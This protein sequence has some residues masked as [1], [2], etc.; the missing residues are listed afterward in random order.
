MKRVFLAFGLCV[1]SFSVMGQAKKPTLMVFP[2]DV[3]C[4]HNGFMQSY[5][6]QGTLTL[7]PDYK[8][9]LQADKDLKNVISMINTL[10]S[11]RGFPLKDLEQTTKSIA[12]LSA[13]DNLLT[14]KTSGASLAENPIDRLRRTAKADI[15][16]EVDWTINATGPKKTVT[17]NLRGLD[18]YTN[19]QVA[20]AQGTGQ[21]SFSSEIPV[22]IEE[23]VLT[24]MDNFTAQLQK[25]F[26]DMFENGREVTIDI[27][28]FE[29]DLGIDLEKEYDGYEL[30]EIIDNWMAEN[31]VN[32]RFNKSDAT[33]NFI[34]YEQVRIPILRPNGMAMDTDF[35]ARELSRFLR[36]A[37]YNIPVKVLNRG[38][39]RCALILGEK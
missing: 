32:H 13:E 14:S 4:T 35:F 12:Q 9:A 20:G 25:H 29:N 10:M 3:W 16:L 19:K 2:S 21:P 26:D 24:N 34:L 39:G 22:L 1:L 38:L 17:Y 6:N 30:T 15:I 23:A 37:P 18:A 11:D 33:E 7:I 8:L 36:V 31:T 5:D 28:V 27:R